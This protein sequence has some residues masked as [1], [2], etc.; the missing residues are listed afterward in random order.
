MNNF[1]LFNQTL[2]Q[3]ANYKY[4]GAII[5]AAYKKT[6]ERSIQKNQLP[7]IPHQNTQI[8]GIQGRN[9]C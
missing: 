8:D 4:L 3:V 5:N 1:R 9:T 2:E 6:M 7:H